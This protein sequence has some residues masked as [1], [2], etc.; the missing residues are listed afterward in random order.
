[1]LSIPPEVASA[2]K[3]LGADYTDFVSNERGANGYLWFARNRISHAAVAIKFY[4]GEPGKRRHEEPRQLATISSPNVLPILDARN[5]SDEWAFFITPRCNGGDLD[6]LIRDRPRAHYAIDVVLGISTGVS[7]IHSCG[8]VHRDLKPGNIVIDQGIPRIADFGSVKTLDKD[9]AETT[10]SQHSVLYRPPESFATGRYSRLGDVYQVGLVAYQLLGGALPYDGTK[11]L[12]ARERKQ[13]E[14]IS[15]VVDR[16]LFVDRALQ[17]RAEMGKLMDL[18]SLPPWITNAAKRVIRA[19][20]NPKPQER[21]GSMADVAAEMSRL[22]TTLRNWQL[23]GTTARLV[24]DDRT[25]ELRCTTA[26]RY[27][28]F[29]QKAGAFRRIPGWE[30]STLDDL[31][32][33]CSG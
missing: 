24:A 8:M 4:A 18:A 10:V 23:V 26:N 25:I 2:L 31:V 29:Q 20:A 30:P 12:T 32:N 21:L 7:A 11:Y 9:T 15:D 13:Y 27:E 28:A 14:A 33:R 19:M 22:R 6:D 3:E 16:S 1:M 17:Q 5:V